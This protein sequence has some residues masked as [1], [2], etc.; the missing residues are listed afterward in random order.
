[1]ERRHQ[2]LKAYTYAQWRL[3][4][5]LAAGHIGSRALIGVVGET[6]ARFRLTSEEWHA[7]VRALAIT[8]A[9]DVDE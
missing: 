4:Q 3:H 8:V 2:R 6:R 5:E 9:A 7:L 1:M